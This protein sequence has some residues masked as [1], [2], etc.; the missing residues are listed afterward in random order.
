MRTTAITR[1]EL[2]ALAD[3]RRQPVRRYLR[4]ALENERLA[5][6]DGRAASSL[7]MECRSDIRDAAE[8][9]QVFPEQWWGVVVFTC[10]GSK[11]GAETVA[12]RFRH[13]RDPSSAE[14]AL[15]QITFPRGSVGHHRIQSTLKGAKQALVAACAQHA[16]FDSVLHS[17]EDFD[18][19]YR[20]LREA[21]VRQW[22]R[23][24]CFDLL[25]RAG[26]LGVGGKRSLP[27]LAY[28]AGS[29]G[30]RKGFTAVFGVD[31]DQRSAQWAEAVLRA[32]AEHWQAV[33]ARV[34]IEWQG[35][36]LYPRDQENFLCVYQ[37]RLARGA[38]GKPC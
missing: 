8:A 24:T 5:A 1:S 35:E 26:A 18:A 25:L 34:G 37:E 30:P 4:W 17:A 2:F 16:F 32:W 19:C 13:P 14:A 9:A 29:T 28:L 10:F 38:L 36:P 6:R 3:A 33:A 20:R 15:D 31:P 11:L 21:R 23:T 12:P 27:E 7:R 22:G